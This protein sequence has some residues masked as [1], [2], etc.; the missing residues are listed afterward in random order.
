[1]TIVTK[2]AVLREYGGPMEIEELQVNE[3]GPDQL[4]V[5]L[6]ASGVCH[7]D[8]SVRTGAYPHPLPCVLGH[9][10]AGIVEKVGAGITD[11]RS[12]QR[13]VCV[14]APSCGACYT[15]LR[16]QS[17]ICERRMELMGGVGFESQ[18]GEMIAPFTGLGTFS[19]Y[20][21]VN[22]Q[23]VVPVQHE[24]P[25][26]QLAL[27]GCAVIT[28]VGAALNAAA[29]KPGASVA[30]VG[31]GGVG[32]SMIQGARIAGATK[33]I[34]VDPDASKRK[35]A[36]SFG[37]TDIVDPSDGSAVEK[38]QALTG[39]R[40]VDYALEAVGQAATIMAAF[41]IA[42]IGGKVVA[43]GVGG[44][45]EFSIMP[46]ELIL[47]ARTFVGSIYGSGPAAK[48]IPM[49]AAM[50]ERGQL[51]LA[52]MVTRTYKLDQ[53]NEAFDAMNNNEV[54]RAVIVYD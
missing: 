24:L 14:A 47:S 39:G 1:M 31:C 10:G 18:S 37:A 51:N 35:M 36:L 32:Q 11:I 3:P 49:L 29:I 16:E 5:R 30:I 28:G 6:E 34:A 22:R 46:T 4:L 45:E 33:I 53:I 54:I 2:A 41:R 7:T 8:E 26:E 19:Q 52:D 20:I 12:G 9:E 17:E 23:A 40:G 44:K 27:L 43:V 21:T 15:C 38:V 25:F 42:R 13:V 50:G 48:E